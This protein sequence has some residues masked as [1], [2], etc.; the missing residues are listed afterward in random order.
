MEKAPAAARRTMR[1][2]LARQCR[3]AACT[4]ALH[5]A[6]LHGR[7]A[8]CAALDATPPPTRAAV[9]P[10]HVSGTHLDNSSA[11]RSAFMSYT[12]ANLQWGSGAMWWAAGSAHCSQ[13]PAAECELCQCC[14]RSAACLPASGPLPPAALAPI[15]RLHNAPPPLPPL[16]AARRVHVVVVYLYL[17]YAMLLLRW[18]YQQ[19]LIMRQHYLRRGDN[20][21][22]W[23]ELHLPQRRSHFAS[24]PRVQQLLRALLGDHAQQVGDGTGTCRYQATHLRSSAAAGS[25]SVPRCVGSWDEAC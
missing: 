16:R 12:M 6:L 24:H 25:A 1:L 18:H 3:L 10:L 8:L 23:R 14:C 11:T 15:P 9:L 5:A 19:Y 7:Q 13:P 21:N 17:G 20:A 4:D 22:Y 2:L